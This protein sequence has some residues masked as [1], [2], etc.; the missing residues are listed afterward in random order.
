MTYPYL[1]TQAFCLLCSGNFADALLVTGE[2]TLSRKKNKSI[3]VDV[4][5]SHCCWQGIVCVPTS[6]LTSKRAR[7]FNA[8]GTW[9]PR[10]MSWVCVKLTRWIHR[11]KSLFYRHGCERT[12]DRY[13]VRERNEQCG[14]SKW[15]FSANERAS[16]R[17]NGPVRVDL[18]ETQRQLMGVLASKKRNKH[19]DT[20]HQPSC[21]N[22]ASENRWKR[23]K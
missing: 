1:C 17:A 15:V 13:G 14:A 5:S 3:I 10:T 8:H 20:S 21:E 12:K 16:G 9:H 11:H 18:A 2:R 22:V 19:N 6:K 23:Q 7:C 4:K